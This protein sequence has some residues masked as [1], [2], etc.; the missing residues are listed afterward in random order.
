MLFKLIIQKYKPIHDDQPLFEDPVGYKMRDLYP[1]YDVFTMGF[2]QNAEDIMEEYVLNVYKDE[3]HYNEF[4]Q[5]MK[6][7]NSILNFQNIRKN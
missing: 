2:W 6:K 3:E 5:V 4:I 7:M 1:Q